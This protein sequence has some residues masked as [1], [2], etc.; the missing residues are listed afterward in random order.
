[1]KLTMAKLKELIRESLSDTEQRRKD[2]L[3]ANTN[4]TEKE[5]EELKDLEHQ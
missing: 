1:M 5:K 2:S 3:D 4:K